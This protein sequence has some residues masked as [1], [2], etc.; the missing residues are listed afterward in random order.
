MFERKDVNLIAKR[1][2]EPKNNL[3]QFIIGPR[4]TGK[5]TMFTQALKHI[6][7]KSHVVS[8]DDVI[9]PTTEWISTE[10]QQ[11]RNLCRAG[12][13][14]VLVID[15]VQKVA[16]WSSTVKGLWDADRR[17]NTNLKVI[18][19]GSSSLLLQ[20]GL[21][22][23]LMGRF[24][25]IRS[26][27]WSFAECASAFNYTL[28]DYLFLGGY[29]AC[30][31]FRNDETRWKNYVRDAIIEPTLS[32]D[33]LEIEE[34]R[35]PALMRN[36]FYLASSYSGQELSYNKMLGQLQEAGSVVTISSYLDAINKANMVA[37]LMKF[38]NK[39]VKRRASSPRFMVYDTSL[40]NACTARGRKHAL[41]DAEYRGHL[42]ESAVGA[43]L[44]ARAATE[45]FEV[46]WWREKNN[47]VDFVLEQEG[48]L[49]AIE[50]KSGN[51]KKQGGMAAFLSEHP[52]AK[53]IVVGG[54]A[55]SAC[56][57]EDFLLDEVEL[58]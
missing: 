9:N 11:A 41:E 54:S 21:E 2:E 27:H 12:N 53:R 18:L 36:L 37:T 10:W 5:T 33:I 24:E 44:L 15:E 40:L 28:E 13:R 16:N 17:N 26:T 52:K 7:L 48:L 29:P 50:V 20:H 6:K 49:I 1:M 22:D 56:S 19:S 58:F 8:A 35:K 38:S 23:S 46:Y 3:I 31:I 57:V 30:E 4:Q 34:I 25:I 39:E 45:H 47:E 32:R 51:T 55:A 42:V 14:V 43:R